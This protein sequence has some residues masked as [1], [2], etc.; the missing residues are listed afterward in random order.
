MPKGLVTV[1]RLL[2]TLQVALVL[3]PLRGLYM[4]QVPENRVIEVGNLTVITE[5]LG[6]EWEGLTVI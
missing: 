4:A 2:A 3:I 5:L 6:M 1:S